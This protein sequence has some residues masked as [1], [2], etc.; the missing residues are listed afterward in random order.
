MVAKKNLLNI[1]ETILLERIKDYL[2]FKPGSQWV[3]E[4]DS[5]LELDT[6]VIVSA[7]V[8]WFKK[9]YITYQLLTFKKR[10]I[11][12]NVDYDVFYPSTDVLYRDDYEHFFSTNIRSE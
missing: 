4:C 11:S 2:Y 12:H 6:Q 3:Y 9:P 7:E 1:T 8:P 10:S 5:T